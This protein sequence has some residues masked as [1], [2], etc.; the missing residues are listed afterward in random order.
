MYTVISREERELL[1]GL[2][3]G[4]S[5]CCVSGEGHLAV[6]WHQEW[7]K[8]HSVAAGEPDVRVCAPSDGGA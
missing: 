4:L 2:I 7:R 3:A 1:Q 5:T 6:A 8:P